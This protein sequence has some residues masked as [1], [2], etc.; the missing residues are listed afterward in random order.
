MKLHSSARRRL[1]W[2]SFGALS[3]AALAVTGIA[4]TS[5]APAAAPPVSSKVAA[6]YASQQAA[7]TKK[8][9]PAPT[10]APVKIARDLLAPGTKAVFFGDSWTAGYTANTPTDGFAYKAGAALGW[11]FNV[12]GVQGTGYL[13]SAKDAVF[14]DR[15]AAMDVDPT[16]KV[17]VLQ[18]GINDTFMDLSKFPAAV[19]K[20]LD[21]AKVTFPNAQIVMLGPG[22]VRVPAEPELL[23]INNDLRTVAQE[24]HLP[25]ISPLDDYWIVASNL[26][27]VIDPKTLH[28]HT[29]GH[30]FLGQKLVESLRKLAS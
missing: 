23:T 10:A 2:A 4:L 11:D 3:V 5:T 22:T 18:G 17:L 21:Q 19:R 20:T 24:R 29:K 13:E 16:V 28:P 8:A 26:S 27:G 1:K 15:L 14:A 12:Q 7:E 30:A 25:F 6:A 9:T